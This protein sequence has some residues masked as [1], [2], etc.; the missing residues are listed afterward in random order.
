MLRAP[1]ANRQIV[2]R[3]AEKDEDAENSGENGAA[4]RVCDQ[5]A[6]NQVRDVEQPQNQGERQTPIPR[7]PNAPDRMRPD[8]AGDEHDAPKGEAYFGGGNGEP[9][10]FGITLG[11]IRNVGHEDDDGRL[12]RSPA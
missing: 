12:H 6:E 2:E 9:V 3:D 7:P 5:R 1:N 11:K 8:W 10:P 4:F